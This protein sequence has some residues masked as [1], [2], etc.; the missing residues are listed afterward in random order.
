MGGGLL[1]RDSSGAAPVE[2]ALLQLLQTST[3]GSS[4]HLLMEV[5]AWRNR[6]P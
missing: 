5:G 2:E 4:L 3:D 6:R 1:E